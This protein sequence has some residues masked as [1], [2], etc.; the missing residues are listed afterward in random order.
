[1]ADAE[2]KADQ[3]SEAE[4]KRRFE[5]AL[6]GARIAGP[7]HVENVPPKK[8]KRQQKSVVSRRVPGKTKSG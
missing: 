1:M 2:K 8:A 6:R 4:K 3:F 5:A 7:Q